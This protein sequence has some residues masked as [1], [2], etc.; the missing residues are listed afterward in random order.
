MATSVAAACKFKGFCYYQVCINPMEK[1]LLGVAMLLS[2]IFGPVPV[3]AVVLTKALTAN[4]ILDNR[5]GALKRGINVP[6]WFSYQKDWTAT[7]TAYL[8]KPDFDFLKK[9]G[10]Q[11]VRL[12]LDIDLFLDETRPNLLKQVNVKV[13]QT[14]V[15]A[16]TKN[17][18]AVMIDMHSVGALEGAEYSGRLEYDLQ[19]PGIYVKFWQNI[20][21]NFSHFN[22][23]KLYFEIL[24]EPI[25]INKEKELHNLNTQVVASIRKAA[26]KHTVIVS[27]GNWA[28]IDGLVSSKP[29]A[30]KNVIYNFHFYEP[31]EFT[32]QGAPWSVP[33][34]CNY[35]QVPYPSTPF[36]VEPYFTGLPES[37]R[38][39]LNDYGQK[40][41]NAEK[42]EKRIDLAFQWANKHKVRVI[43]NEIGVY[44]PYSDRGMRNRWLFDTRMA[45]E[46][47]KIGWGVWAY[48]KDFGLVERLKIG[49]KPNV[50]HNM[51]KAL[52]LKTVY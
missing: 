28:N 12:P 6:Y 3:R 31:F 43:A 45:L 14:A 33:D 2:L 36:N 27:A 34:I 26:P 50:D 19:F 16:M 42:I 51:L 25:F 30:D 5:V 17:G 35:N 46:K 9:S 38:W 39:L 40:K 21:A 4:Q 7:S 37:A 11:Y 24:N 52:G 47:R 41:W 44:K 22:P 18:L 13:L 23:D 49:D 29:L 8:L 15:E 48:D 1:K 10:I 20:A 32:H